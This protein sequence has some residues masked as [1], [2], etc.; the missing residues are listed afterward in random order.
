MVNC[1][2]KETVDIPIYN[3]KKLSFTDL[4]ISNSEEKLASIHIT[5]TH[6]R[7]IVIDLGELNNQELA[8]NVKSLWGAEIDDNLYFQITNIIKR[9][10]ELHGYK[11]VLVTYPV[12][13]NKNGSVFTLV[14]IGTESLYNLYIT[15]FNKINSISNLN[16]NTTSVVVEDLPKYFSSEDFSR[17]SAH[18][19]GKPITAEYLGKFINEISDF[20]TLNKDSLADVLIPE[21]N[22]SNGTLKIGLKIGSYPLRNL[23][24][25][26]NLKEIQDPGLKIKKKCFCVL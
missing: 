21:Q 4:I 15:S 9:I 23:V 6:N 19:L 1:L 20:I 14:S 12:N 25:L 8:A 26:N 24:F 7:I 13:L 18:Y 11:K 5:T 22:I 3:K 2:A 16:K 10:Y 17:I